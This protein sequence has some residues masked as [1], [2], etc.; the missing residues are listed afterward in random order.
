MAHV[1]DVPETDPI[2]TEDDSP[3]GSGDRIAQ[4]DRQ[5]YER[6]PYYRPEITRRSTIESYVSFSDDEDEDD[7]DGS[8]ITIFHPGYRAGESRVP[9]WER[10]IDER[11]PIPARLPSLKMPTT[12]SRTPTIPR[13]G[14]SHSTR[15]PNLVTFDKMDPANPH[16]WPSH[17]RWT[18]TI[19]IALFAFISPMASTMVAPALD[20]ISREFGVQSDIEEFLMM[21]IFLL[22]F[23]I[24]PF[25][26]GTLYLN[27]IVFE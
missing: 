23:A 14:R 18:S 17:R 4:E 6:Q 22:A 19:L 16:N 15:D 20:E 11:L 21:S 2:R 24:G 7:D 10:E 13:S 9:T 5:E 25:L 3:R 8:S 1:H 12:P 27:S 26:W